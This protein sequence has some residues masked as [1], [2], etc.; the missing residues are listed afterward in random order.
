[1]K[2]SI[3]FALLL[4]G[5]ILFGGAAA[6]H[7][8]YAL[9]DGTNRV[10]LE[11]TIAKLEWRNPHAFIW[12]YAH[13][14]DSDGQLYGL[15]TDSINALVRHGWSK[16]SLKPGD[17]ITLE[18]YALA[19][20]RPGGHLIRAVLPDGSELAGEPG[21]VNAIGSGVAGGPRSAATPGRSE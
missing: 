20:G 16:T 10:T 19:D 8:S 18:F 13:G 9:F 21:P 7:H 4:C 1:M 11:A 17:R 5:A 3:P 12:A 14:K 6:A 15:E 2:S